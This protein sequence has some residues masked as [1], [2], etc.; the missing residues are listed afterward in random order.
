MFH[1]RNAPLSFGNGVL[2]QITA[3]YRFLGSRPPF[4]GTPIAIEYR[5][6]Y[7]FKTVVP[8]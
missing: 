5:T 8:D 1:Q 6:Q 3:Y 4:D 2:P 7:R